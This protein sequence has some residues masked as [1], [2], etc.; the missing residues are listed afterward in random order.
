MNVNSTL[1][2]EEIKKNYEHLFA[3]NEKSKGGSFYLQSKVFRA[4]ERLDE[5]LKAKSAESSDKKQKQ[6]V[7]N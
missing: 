2:P 6:A 5:E 7:E 3:V 1:D 4:K